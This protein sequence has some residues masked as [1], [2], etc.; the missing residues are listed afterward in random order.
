MSTGHVLVR[1]TPDDLLVG[2][3]NVIYKY[4]LRNARFFAYTVQ[5]SF[6]NSELLVMM[7][8]NLQSVWLLPG[9]KKKLH[10]N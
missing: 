9:L 5:S 4:F 8:D 10:F 6:L 2:W 7:A 3:I 1:T